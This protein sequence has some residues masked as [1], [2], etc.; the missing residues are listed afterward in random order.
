MKIAIVA[1]SAVPFLVGGAEKLWWGLL[2]AINQRTQHHAELIKL[3]SPEGDFWALMSS[4]RAFSRLDLDHFDLVITTKYP[5]W[6]LGHN[7]HVCY[8]Q[9]KL[10]GLYDTYHLTGLPTRLHSLP[11]AF[12][13][14]VHLMAAHE[15]DRN[16]LDEFFDALFTLKE[17]AA[18][19]DAFAFPG[20]LSRQIVHYLDGIALKPGAISRYLAISRNV[21]QRDAYFPPGVPVDV[22]HHPSNL[23]G[24]RQGDYRYVFTASRLDPPKRVELLIRAFRKTTDPIEFLIAGTGPQAKHLAELAGDDKRIQFLGHVSDRD[25]VNLY[26]DALYVPFIPYDED[27]GLITIEAM[28]SGKAVLTTVDAGGVNEF[29]TH[30]STGLSVA[31]DVDALSEAMSRLVKERASTIAMGE[32]ARSVVGNI[33]WENTLDRLLAESTTCKAAPSHGAYRPDGQTDQVTVAVDFPVYPPRGGGQSR[34][35]H[36]YRAIARRKPTTLVTLCDEMGNAGSYRLALDLTEIRVAKSPSHLDRAGTLEQQFGTTVGDIATLLYQAETPEYGERLKRVVDRSSLVVASHPYLYPAIESIDHGRLWYEAHNVEIDMKRAVLGDHP[37]AEAC[38]SQVAAVE[39]ALCQQAELILVCSQADAL[40]LASLYSVQDDKFILVPNGVDTHSVQFTP[41][42]ERRA[43]KNRLGLSH[44][45]TA[46]FMGSWHPPNIEA[47]NRLKE[48]ARSSPNIDIVVAGSVTQHLDLAH[49]PG[50][51]HCLGVLTDAELAV[52]L[53][54]VDVALNPVTSGSGTNLK[55]LHYAAAGL[56]ILTTEFGNRG[57]DFIQGEHI[58]QDELEDF[59][60]QLD[61]LSTTDS[62]TLERITRNA[63]AL[64]EQTYDWDAIAKR[65]P[66]G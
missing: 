49:T 59:P 56:P 14:L 29:V 65:I 34:I 12:N 8:L 23:V 5:A 58:W 3:P 61:A 45:L 30:E 60:R 13:E 31:P 11:S 55:M 38:L 10:R 7:N 19:S 51:M 46:L 57:L 25:L 26:S 2:D 64:T 52:V 33:D 37:D 53:A 21:R 24:L 22:V 15:H 32:N 4:Y 1:P 47:A 28:Q 42:D 39:G 20:P 40:R 66:I 50:N 54:S 17:D 44:R 27:Y 62:Q 35:Y 48:I 16:V 9:H 6:M 63:R 36:L 41:L 43:N 18:L